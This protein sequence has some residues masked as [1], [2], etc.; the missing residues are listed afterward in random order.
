ML[1]ETKNEY[2]IPKIVPKWNTIWRRI[3]PKA[4]F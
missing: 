1:K 3:I 2:Y 4:I